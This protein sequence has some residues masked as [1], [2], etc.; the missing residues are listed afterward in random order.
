MG[1]EGEK[2]RNNRGDASRVFPSYD[3][4]VDWRATNRLE[5]TS[6]ERSRI[7]K[8]FYT[9]VQ[10]LARWLGALGMTPNAI[11]YASLAVSVL[12]GVA[13]A[14]GSA[15]WGAV[16]VLVG[17][18]MDLLDGALARQ[19]AMTTRWGAILDSTTDRISDAAP[20]VGLAVYFAPWGWPLAIPL[21]ILLGSFV[22][23]YVRARAANLGI[24]LPE[25]PMRRAERILAT[26]LACVI[27]ELNGASFP[28]GGWMLLALAVEASLVASAT[29]YTLFVVHQRALVSSE[30][31]DGLAQLPNRGRG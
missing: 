20:L 4:G 11:T 13:I 1:R 3:S 28:A 30:P 19:T 7:A 12:A 31:K 18:A 16:A 8:R 21:L 9:L 25:L 26:A 17:G 10:Q 14:A 23:S 15:G 22:I 5:G 24:T 29:V 27:G 6:W 2:A